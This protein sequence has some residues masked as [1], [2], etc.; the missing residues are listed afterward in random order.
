MMPS[1]K[2]ST[3]PR[4]WRRLALVALLAAGATLAGC[5]G[6]TRDAF[7]P[8]RLHVFGDEAS[9]LEGDGRRHGINGLASGGGIDC[10]ARP[11]WVQSVAA[12]TGR[13][14]AEC[15]P[16]GAVQTAFMRAS[17]DARVADVVAALGTYNLM[18]AAPGDLITVA[19]GLHD[20]LDLYARYPTTAEAALRT[21]AEQRGQQLA[22]ALNAV[23][24]VDGPVALLS[25]VPDVGRTP[26]ALGQPA[27]HAAVL[28]R[29]A[30]AF[31]SGLRREIVNDGRRIGLVDAF[32]LVQVMATRPQDY[33]IANATQAACNVAL[34]DC[35]TATLV[36]GASADNHLWADSLRLAPGAH[37][38]LASE[39]RLRLR[40]NPF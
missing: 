3:P 35:T 17:V 24:R 22:A 7:Q 31:N 33:G 12:S 6:E 16:G 38:R 10:A 20:V 32:N 34:P 40:D 37:S 5:G 18:T 1:P 14:F 21:E 27:G 23:V 13:V 30:E 29:L 11:I 28:T 8:A 15:N 19:V 39:A 9:R 36:P 26:F 25:T 4:R 2:P